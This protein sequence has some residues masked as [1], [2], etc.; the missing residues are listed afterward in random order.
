MRVDMD[1]SLKGLERFLSSLGLP[2]GPDRAI[3]HKTIVGLLA[4]LLGGFIGWLISEPYHE[5]FSFWRDFFILVSVG[6]FVCLF[7]MSIDSIFERSTSAFL[8]SA[9]KAALL[10]LVILVPSVLA[11]KTVVERSRLMSLG[12]PAIKILVLD[13][14]G[15]MRG[16]PLETLKSAAKAYGSTVV[17]ADSKGDTLVA[18]VAFSDQARVIAEPTRD[19]H[20]FITQVNQMTAS[21]ATRMG[22]GLI[23]ARRILEGQ[24]IVKTSAAGDPKTSRGA[25][26]INH[27][28]IMVTDGKPTGGASSVLDALPFFIFNGIPVHTVG[29]GKDYDK[30]L[31]ERISLKTDGTFVAADD[32]A[33]LVP[34]MEEF[35]RQGLAQAGASSKGYASFLTR[36]AGWVII[37]T[38]IGIC[39]AIPRK[40]ARALL[41]GAAGGLAGGLLGAGLFELFQFLLA[42]A[43]IQSG[44]A[45]RFVGFSVLGASIGFAVPF[46]ESVSKVAWLRVV[47]GAQLGRLIILDRSPMILGSGPGSDV[48]IGG[49]PEVEENHARITRKGEA[50][51]VEALGRKG[52]VKG[53]NVTRDAE[54]SPEEVFV[55]GETKLLY[56]TKVTLLKA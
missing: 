48:T 11:T 23:K 55:I 20:S 33:R 36:I 17:G 42:V 47:D 22:D 51:R 30:T 52:F 34:V 24:G 16:Y 40:T 56:L 54:I 35:A 28:V 21:G 31:L 4:G 15:S 50:I 32:I 39:A 6:F 53:G 9:A 5:D 18:C 37:G 26:G 10:S 27:E 29:A 13:V 1:S 25:S 19:F 46:A 3:N 2:A 49:D 8:R 44:I 43:G 41:F 7:V 45:N 14:S 12:R 38:A